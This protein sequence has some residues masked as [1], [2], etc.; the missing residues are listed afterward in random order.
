MNPDKL[1]Q[2]IFDWFERRYPDAGEWT[3][4]RFHCYQDA[5]AALRAVI[6]TQR[7]ESD[8]TNS[9]LPQLLWNC[10]HH[11]RVVLRDAAEGY[12]RFGATEAVAAIAEFQALFER[13]EPVC[14]PLVEACGRTQDFSLFGRWCESAAAELRSDREEVCVRE[15]ERCR[16]EWLRSHGSELVE[17]MKRVSREGRRDW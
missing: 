14:R 16:A 7:V 11:W 3:N 10:F 17:L 8:L 5:P 9:G 15:G 12:G 1:E 4:P 2:R 13:F 6:M